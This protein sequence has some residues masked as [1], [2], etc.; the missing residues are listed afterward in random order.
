MFLQS[1]VQKSAIICAHPRCGKN[2][3]ILYVSYLKQLPLFLYFCGPLKKIRWLSVP[4]FIQIAE[5]N[6]V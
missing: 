2:S 6:Y 3:Y 1:K 4:C 5:L